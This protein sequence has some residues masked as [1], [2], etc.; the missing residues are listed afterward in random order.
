MDVARGGQE[1]GRPKK[2]TGTSK[3]DF[4]KVKVWLGENMDH[5]YVLS[6]FLICR[7][8]TVTKIPYIKAVK[9]AL[10]TKKYLVDNNLQDVTQTELENVLFSIIRAKGFN[11]QYIDC[12]RMVTQFYQQRRPLCIIICGTAWTGKSTIAQ[13]LAS[14]INIPNVMQTDVIYE[15][16]RAGGDS[17]LHATPLWCRLGLS[18]AGLV[19]EFRREA[20]VVRKGMDGDLIKTLTDGKPIIIEGA[21]LDPGLYIQDFQ[22]RGIIMLP[23]R[24]AA[25]ISPIRTARTA[26]AAAARALC[27]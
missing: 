13:Q 8:L 12:Y 3:Y 6:R 17:P 14:R 9:I 4:F 27:S 22:R 26:A 2:R 5:Y 25:A 1:G 16:L 18:D 20:R 10:E 15:L 24:P 23:A 11:E 21:H 19:A 7:M